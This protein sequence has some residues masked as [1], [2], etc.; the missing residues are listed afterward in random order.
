VLVKR[1]KVGLELIVYFALN[2][3]L[4]RQVDFRFALELD[5]R[6]FSEDELVLGELFFVGVELFLEERYFILAHTVLEFTHLRL[7]LLF[8]LSGL[9]AKVLFLGLDNY[10]KLRLFSLYNFN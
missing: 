2:E 6:L 10:G 8:H 3:L 7:M 4:Q 5:V 1:F 9:V